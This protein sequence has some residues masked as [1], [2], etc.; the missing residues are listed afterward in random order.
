MDLISTLGIEGVGFGGADAYGLPRFNIQGFDQV[1][2]SLLC[3]PCEYDR[4][5][6]KSAIA[7]AGVSGAFAACRRRLAVLQLGHARLLPESWVYQFTNGFTTRTASNDGTGQSLANFLL[8]LPTVAQRQAGLPSMN[9]RQTN[10]EAF[11]QDD[12]RIETI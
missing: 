3:T 6:S 1:G 12:W 7:S 4:K 11:V 5:L 9:M 2:D 10:Y 8:G